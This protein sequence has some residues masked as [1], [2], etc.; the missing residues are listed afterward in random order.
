MPGAS[1][2]D[3][4][5]WYLSLSACKS[6]VSYVL[7]SKWVSQQFL[8]GTQYIQSHSV[9][10][11]VHYKSWM[12]HRMTVMSRQF[13]HD[14]HAYCYVF[15]VFLESRLILVVDVF[16]FMLKSIDLWFKTG[17]VI[18]HCYQLLPTSQHSLCNSSTHH[19]SC[20]RNLHNITLLINRTVQQS[21]RTEA[22]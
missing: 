18:G 5:I 13:P 9:P 3:R 22:S 4:Q 20:N 14:Y 19:A 1:V 11:K 6:M 16:Q 2:R 15:D 17:F 7:G 21:L 10:L 12:Y 8:N